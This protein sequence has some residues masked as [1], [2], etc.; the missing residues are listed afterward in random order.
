MKR[1][2]KKNQL[3]KGKSGFLTREFG[4]IPDRCTFTSKGI[5]ISKNAIDPLLRGA[6]FLKG[7][8]YG[9][10]DYFKKSFKTKCT[11]DKLLSCYSMLQ[12]F[13]K[14]R[15]ISDMLYDIF[16]PN[17]E[18]NQNNDYDEVELLNRFTVFFK[19]VISIIFDY[20]KLNP[21]TDKPLLLGALSR[22]F[23]VILDY[24]KHRQQLLQYIRAK[25][26]NDKVL[27]K[28]FNNSPV[29]DNE[30]IEKNRKALFSADDKLFETLISKKIDFNRYYDD[31][32]EIFMEEDKNVKLYNNPD[33]KGPESGSG[34]KGYGEYFLIFVVGMLGLSFIV[35]KSINWNNK[36]TF[37]I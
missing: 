9:F 35:E 7:E 31:K 23:D 18:V 30:F 5:H 12:C 22:Q 29:G 8:T 17:E 34:K 6:F 1:T 10:T 25:V 32:M 37:Y 28:Q 4:N 14:S 36:D 13:N 24:E 16:N 33:F 21:K 20:I 19:I 15:D 3:G 11:D 2:K 27:L 26:T